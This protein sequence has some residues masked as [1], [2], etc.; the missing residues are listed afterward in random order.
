LSGNDRLTVAVKPQKNM[1][2]IVQKQI[3]PATFVGYLDI[4]G[5]IESKQISELEK[6]PL[7]F[8]VDTSG[9]SYFTGSD[10]EFPHA[11]SWLLEDIKHNK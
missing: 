4:Y 7:T 5:I 2:E 11:L 9:D 3:E 1:N 6:D 10:K 8:L